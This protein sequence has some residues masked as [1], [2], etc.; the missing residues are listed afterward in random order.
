MAYELRSVAYTSFGPDECC[1]CYRLLITSAEEFR[2]AI[3]IQRGH[4]RNN[5]APLRSDAKTFAPSLGVVPPHRDEIH[6]SICLEPFPGVSHVLTQLSFRRHGHSSNFQ[7]IF[8][9]A[10][11]S[12]S[13]QPPLVL[14][15]RKG[16]RNMSCRA[17]KRRRRQG[18]TR[19]S[20]VSPRIEAR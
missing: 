16:K 3:G 11:N 2:T 4:H 10:K 19:I 7:S 12:D 15:L 1:R 6:A 8:D 13:K 18:S 20:M 9:R 5:P 17:G 14:S